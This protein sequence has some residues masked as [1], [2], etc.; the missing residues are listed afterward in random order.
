MNSNDPADHTIGID[1]LKAF[2]EIT[3]EIQRLA[4]DRPIEHFHAQALALLQRLL[5]FDRAW[6]G[7][8]AIVDGL[9]EMHSSHLLNLPPEYVADW[10]SI[11]HEDITVGLTIA[12]PRKTVLIGSSKSTPG[13]SWL[14]K[15]HGF[16]EFLC[17][18][19]SDP[20]TGLIDHLTLYRAPDADAFTA[21]D[22]LLLDNLMGHL[23]AAVSANQIRTLVTKRESLVHS[24]TLALAVCDARGT[25]HCAERG[26]IDLLLNEWPDWIGPQLPDTISLDGYQGSR[27]L[28]EASAVGD[29]LLLTGRS[30]GLM[31]HLSARENEVARRFGE[32][33]TYKEIARDLGL[34]P[35]TVRHHIRTIYSKLGVNDKVSIAHLIHAPVD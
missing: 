33:K 15:R 11:R 30:H 5:P 12:T 14:G 27:L 32:G 31:H 35:N 25:L 6:W 17:V 2:S 1:L 10:Q 13:L 3:L 19:H 34:A 22:K 28:L 9:P 29:L 21:Q 20:Q 16:R 24:S 4:R 7:R 23:T 18:I 26:F 8:A